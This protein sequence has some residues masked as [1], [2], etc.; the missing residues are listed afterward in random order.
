M[1]VPGKNLV[2][3]DGYDAVVVGAGPNG[4]AAAITIARAGRSVLLVEARDR[5]GGGCRTEELTAPGYRHDVC[6][7]IHPLARAA[8]FFRSLPLDELGIDWIEPEIP[9]AHPI[10]ERR[11]VTARRDLVET[12]ANLGPDGNAYLRLMTPLVKDSDALIREF[13][14]PLRP[15]RHPLAFARFGLR[16]IR[17]AQAL[18][19][20]FS[21]DGARALFSGVAA[22]SML[23]LSSLGTGGYGL[24]LALLAHSVG[25]PLARGGSQTIVDGME[26]YLRS[27]GGEVETGRTVTTLEDLP[28]ARAYLLDLVP[29]HVAHVAA[30]RLPDR[31]LR[32]LARFRHGVGAFKV[33]WALSEPVPWTNPEL[34]RAGTIHLGGT[35]EEVARS[36]AA[37][38]AGQVPEPPFVLAAQ[39]S[40]FDD[41]RAPANRHTLWAYCHVPHGS[42]AD[43]TGAVEAQIERFA[44]GFR[45]TVIARRAAG[46]PEM[47]AYNSNYVGGDINGGMQ[48]IGQLFTRPTW[49]LR[50]YNTPARE[51]YICSSS[52]PPG[53]GVHGMCGYWAARHALRRAL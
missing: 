2:V 40:I 47:E 22:H 31:Y 49:S 41:S 46:P 28:R 53:G 11:A 38:N 18:A 43:M 35:F 44:P 17:S 16:A 42:G 48:D 12:A 29:R 4:L 30:R 1:S 3:G 33:D 51:V 5:V 15:P 27:L 14:G 26:R 9:Y 50:G 39:Q 10:D 20:R 23:P 7:A 37:S 45:D 52:T 32:A 6:S 19:R 34:R 24:F 25:W 8:P 21:D 13:L 36:E